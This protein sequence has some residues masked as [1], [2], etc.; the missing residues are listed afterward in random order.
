MYVWHLRYVRVI[1]LSDTLFLHVV[2]DWMHNRN[3]ISEAGSSLESSCC[4]EHSSLIGLLC[5]ITHFSLP[6]FTTPLLDLPLAFP[7]VSPS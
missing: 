3:E 7:R 6:I 4:I 1:R 2:K 5:E